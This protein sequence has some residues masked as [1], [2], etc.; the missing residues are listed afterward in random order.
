MCCCGSATTPV[1]RAGRARRPPLSL[2]ARGPNRASVSLVH[3]SIS[4]HG[5]G[6]RSGAAAS[7]DSSQSD[8][9]RMQDAGRCAPVTQ[10]STGPKGLDFFS[11]ISSLKLN[12]RTGLVFFRSFGGTFTQIR[13]SSH[14]PNSRAFSPPTEECANSTRGLQSS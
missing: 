8:S 1:D 4:S 5:G 2:L 7:A 6:P 12:A 9:Q 10:H 14:T 11:F 3:N 13:A